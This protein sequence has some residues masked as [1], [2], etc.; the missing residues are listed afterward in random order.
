MSAE[1]PDYIKKAIERQT[2]LSMELQGIMLTNVYSASVEFQV[3][4]NSRKV[5]V[6]RELAEVSGTIQ[7]YIDIG[8]KPPWDRDE[9]GT[10]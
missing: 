3:E 1:L 2:V 5:K 8:K 6:E 9:D 4:L 7:R 10:A